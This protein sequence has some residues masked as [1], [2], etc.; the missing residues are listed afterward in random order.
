MLTAFVIESYQQLQADNAKGTALLLARIS[1]QLESFTLSPG[2]VNSSV[3]AL[4]LPTQFSPESSA[5]WINV[6]W[7]L[8]L[9]FSLAAALFG[10][11]AKQWLREYLKWYSTVSSPRENVL[12][13]QIRYEA[14]NEWNVAAS[15]SSIPALLELSLILFVCGLVILLWTLD[16]VVAIVFT[17]ATAVFLVI[18][19]SFTLLPAFFKRCPYKSPTAWAC[20][21]A[22]DFTMDT[23]ERCLN[24][25]RLR[26]SRVDAI[27]A[28]QLHWKLS[29]LRLRPRTWR[30]RDIASISVPYFED[31]RGNKQDVLAV[32]HE[33]IASELV[34][35]DGEGRLEG[36]PRFDDVTP[37][38]VNQ[39]LNA[40]A[41]LVHLLRALTWVSVATQDS[42]IHEQVLRCA[43]S[44]HSISAI[45][46]GDR[47]NISEILGTNGIRNV[48]VWFLLSQAWPSGRISRQLA[49]PTT[50]RTMVT[51]T[52]RQCLRMGYTMQIIEE[53]RERSAMRVTMRW[54][55]LADVWGGDPSVFWQYTP[56][57]AQIITYLLASDIRTTIAK[58][59]TFYYGREDRHIRA[60]RAVEL[61][62]AL[63]LVLSTNNTVWPTCMMLLAETYNTII[64]SVR[65]KQFERGFPGLRW[66]IL[67]LICQFLYVDINA[68]GELIGAFL[69]SITPNTLNSITVCLASTAAVQWSMDPADYGALAL[70]WDLSSGQEDQHIFVHAAARYMRTFELSGRG[71]PEA[72]RALLDKMCMHLETCLQRS[73]PNAGCYDDLPRPHRLRSLHS[74]KV[75]VLRATYPQEFRRLVE[76][77]DQSN[78]AGLITGE[79]KNDLEAWLVTFRQDQSA[80]MHRHQGKLSTSFSPLEDGDRKPGDVRLSPPD[81]SNVG[82]NGDISQGSQTRAA[83]S[84]VEGGS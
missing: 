73:V 84:H 17:I 61:L 63:W 69:A 11:L 35:L 26:L 72:E 31:P 42:R 76:L 81:S 33:E 19:S 9:L 75:K 41:H 37:Q 1:L 28:R 79:A 43:S 24:Y 20:A 60:R 74:A 44:M 22:F 25:G 55:A 54:D 78:T 38:A 29:N 32:M 83:P 57:E 7:F 34:P 30:A 27:R 68:D 14:W 80:S 64:K 4:V 50:D 52:M 67:D 40:V 45:S 51:T 47:A 3:P 62:C 82:H 10:I 46:E 2:F 39:T 48:S 15:I 6:L 16:H 5:L 18:I 8:S 59:L 71:T 58:L 77:L 23:L 53:G 56:Q 13:R 36:D 70:K 49:N 66:A 21:L 12:V 65:R